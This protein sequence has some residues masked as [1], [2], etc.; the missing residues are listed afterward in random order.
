MSIAEGTFGTIPNPER[1]HSTAQHSTAQ[2]STAQ[3]STA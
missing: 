2:H 3:H 1:Q